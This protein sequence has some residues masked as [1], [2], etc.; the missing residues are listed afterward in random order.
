MSTGYEIGI[1]GGDNR[2][3]FMAASFLKKAF[4]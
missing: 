3:V 2:Q 4:L 1:F